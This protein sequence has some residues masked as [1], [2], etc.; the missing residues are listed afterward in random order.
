MGY[1]GNG[2]GQVSLQVSL[3][4]QVPEEGAESRGHQ[5]CSLGGHR[6][7]MAQDKVRN[8]RRLQFS[9]KEG[10]FVEALDKKPT[11][12]GLVLEDCVCDEP[13]LGA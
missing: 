12:E 8:V 11:N 9:P 10:S 13:A 3:L 4:K 1:S 5:L 6:R 7:T 2:S